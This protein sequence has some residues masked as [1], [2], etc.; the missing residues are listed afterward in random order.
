MF[1][2]VRPLKTAVRA[3]A[4]LV[5]FI[6]YPA[7]VAGAVII[8][9]SQCV[10]VRLRRKF[11]LA[12]VPIILCLQP[13]LVRA[14]HLH[15]NEILQYFSGYS[16]AKVYIL[17]PAG[18]VET[19]ISPATDVQIIGWRHS[20]A[21][22][23]FNKVGLVECAIIIRE[24]I[25]ASRLLYYVEGNG[26]H[27][28][29]S[30]QHEFSALRGCLV[31]EALSIP[32]VVEIAGNYEM[33]RRIWGRTIYFPLFGLIPLM[34]RIFLKFNNALIGWPLRRA[35]CV[36]GRNKN[37][38]EH[39]FALGVSVERLAMI[40]IRLAQSFSA[41][42]DSVVPLAGRYMLFVARM[43]KEKFPLDILEVY[44]KLAERYPDLSLVM[45]GDGE[46]LP[47]VKSKAISMN[48]SDRIH[49]LGAKPYEEVIRWTRGATFAFETYS[50]SALAEKMIC[51]IPVVA[52]DIEWMSEIVI[53]NYSGAL[54]RF[55][56]INEAF[57]AC[58][59]FLDDPKYA[60]EVS[61]LGRQL[62]LAMF[63]PQTIERKERGVFEGA[64]E[65][66]RLRCQKQ[67]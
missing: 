4:L 56:N 54:V 52:Y 34:G 20:R 30:M 55:R 67:G 66:V 28:I 10:F 33:L 22:D 48:C 60:D 15:G 9:V 47:L 45:I 23:L 2:N 11:K 1:D 42:K 43:A 6:L 36:I 58:C 18:E 26:I 53:D 24:I 32:H 16:T 63:D 39:A 61:R 59:K 38:Y 35:Y 14:Y 62:A 13:G 29:R 57:C 65:L 5:D 41:G 37:N 44:Q 31:S 21:F 7:M 46:Y 50:G 3:L 12:G 64:L 19:E 27:C 40:R 25:A 17:D 8:F 49:V 51:A